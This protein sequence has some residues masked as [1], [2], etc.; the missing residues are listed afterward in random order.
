MTEPPNKP[1]WKPVGPSHV[2]LAT[3]KKEIKNQA[4]VGV[5]FTDGTHIKI[6]L[7]PGVRLNWDDELWI[8]LVPIM[9]YEE[10]KKRK[11]PPMTAEDQKMHDDY[12]DIPF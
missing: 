4:A 9:E 5:A 1:T 11:S 10:R 6:R 2:L 12:K 8:K 7:N 3:S